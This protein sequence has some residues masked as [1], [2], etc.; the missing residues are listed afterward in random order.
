[1]QN[2][3]SKTAAL[4]DSPGQ[5]CFF[6]IG[7]P[8]LREHKNESLRHTTNHVHQSFP[9]FMTKGCGDWI[10][11]D[12]YQ[13]HAAASPPALPSKKLTGSSK[14]ENA[15]SFPSPRNSG[16]DSDSEVLLPY[17]SKRKG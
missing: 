8:E 14:N 2:Q 5:H 17:A 11:R 7:D 4:Q 10:D 13:H 16:S 15:S 12:K 1:M 3:C 6:L 9:R